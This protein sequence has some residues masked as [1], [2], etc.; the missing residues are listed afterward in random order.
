MRGDLPYPVYSFELAAIQDRRLFALIRPGTEG[1]V[2]KES[3]VLNFGGHRFRVLKQHALAYPE[4]T[5]EHI[6]RAGFKKAT[7][8]AE[9]KAADKWLR[10]IGADF[11]L[12]FY[13]IEPLQR[14][15]NEPLT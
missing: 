4:L 10:D 9:R 11:C 3:K 1:N 6:S 12:W 5:S 13:D 15:S 7:L 2:V 8:E 14:E